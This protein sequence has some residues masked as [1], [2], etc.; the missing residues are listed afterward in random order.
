M[1][2]VWFLIYGLYYRD[3]PVLVVDAIKAIFISLIPLVA[4]LGLIVWGIFYLEDHGNKVL[5]R[6]KKAAAKEMLERI[7]KSAH[8]S[9]R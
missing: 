8:T 2:M 9:R 6:S 7:D 1:M 3:E 4:P 5:F